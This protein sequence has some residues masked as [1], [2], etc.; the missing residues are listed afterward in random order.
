[1]E[2]IYPDAVKFDFRVLESVLGNHQELTCLTSK[3]GYSLSKNAEIYDSLGELVMY[4]WVTRC[5]NDEENVQVEILRFTDISGNVLFTCTGNERITITS[6]DAL[7]GHLAKTWGTP[8]GIPCELRGFE[9][10]SI[11]IQDSGKEFQF[12]SNGANIATVDYKRECGD[13][14]IETKL[15]FPNSLAVSEKIML[16]VASYYLNLLSS[17]SPKYCCN[18]RCFSYWL[19]GAMALV[20]IFFLFESMSCCNG[21]KQ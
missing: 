20:Y 1:M 12:Q 3:T 5:A 6:G 17:S 14:Q 21:C 9:N 7:V 11:K 10:N 8:N 19:M 2:P 13:G 15:T 16:I 4:A 18:I